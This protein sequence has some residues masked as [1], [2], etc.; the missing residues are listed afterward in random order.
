MDLLTLIAA[1]AALLTSLGAL[2][3]ST[4]N[5]RKTEAE[6]RSVNQGTSSSV[7][8]ELRL[9]LIRLHEKIAAQTE[10]IVAAKKSAAEAVELITA[11]RERIETVL[12]ENV[13]LAQENRELR[14]KVRRTREEGGDE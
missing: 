6:T 8:A 5:R 1:I 9:E 12:A 10:E 14:K 4:A 3:N 2:Y 11:L 7:N 13:R